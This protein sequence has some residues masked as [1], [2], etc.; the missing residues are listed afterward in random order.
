MP[1]LECLTINYNYTNVEFFCSLGEVSDHSADI[2]EFKIWS[3]NQIMIS[4]QWIAVA[5]QSC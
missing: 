5:I 2:M 4:K 3:I 1:A